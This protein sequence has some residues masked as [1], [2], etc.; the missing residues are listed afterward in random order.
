MD[1]VNNLR[2]SFTEHTGIGDINVKFSQPWYYIEFSDPMNCEMM[3]RACMFIK[4]KFSNSGSF[5]HLLPK[6]VAHEK[7]VAI[8]I[9]KEM[10][11]RVY[12]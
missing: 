4:D 9:S 7:N 10:A 11:E 12:S 8:I 6:F 5:A 1:T 2:K 3:E